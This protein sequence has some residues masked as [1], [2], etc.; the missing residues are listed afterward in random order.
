MTTAMRPY[1]NNNYNQYVDDGCLQYKSIPMSVV[2]KVIKVEHSK[3]DYDGIKQIYN[4]VPPRPKD[5]NALATS[6]ARINNLVY[7]DAVPKISSGIIAEETAEVRTFVANQSGS[8][9]DDFEFPYPPTQYYVAEDPVRSSTGVRLSPIETNSG[10]VDNPKYGKNTSVSMLLG[11]YEPT[12]GVVPFS[13]TTETQTEWVMN[14]EEG[15]IKR[16]V[17]FGN[18]SGGFAGV[19]DSG[20]AFTQTALSK[21]PS[22]KNITESGGYSSTEY[23]KFFADPH[24]QYATTLGT[25]TRHLSRA[26]QVGRKFGNYFTPK[27]TFTD[28][29]A[30]TA[31]PTATEE[32]IREL[33]MN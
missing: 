33:K 4:L 30:N 22:G 29:T 6:I 11:D 32:V 27:R 1:I 20:D 9:N 31:T 23:P 3:N 10:M 13:T 26:D 21:P 17:K 5:I 15:F 19:Y 14:K 25:P 28:D 16:Q 8:D 2:N 7:S 18:L 12:S 24:N